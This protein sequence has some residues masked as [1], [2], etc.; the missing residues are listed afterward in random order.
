MAFKKKKGLLLHGNSIWF[1][2]TPLQYNLDVSFPSIPYSDA[3]W[4]GRW[5]ASWWPGYDWQPFRSGSSAFI[6]DPRVSAMS[7]CPFPGGFKRCPE[8]PKLPLEAG[9]QKGRPW[10]WAWLFSRPVVGCW[11]H[12][13]AFLS[14]HFLTCSAAGT[15]SALERSRVHC[16]AF[17]NVKLLPEGISTQH[18]CFSR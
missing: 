8:Q 16:Q 12:R 2:P 14:L 11:T 13:S 7:A 6:S 5:W 1:L 4:V 3:G 17:R 9:L 10:V 15:V 18:I